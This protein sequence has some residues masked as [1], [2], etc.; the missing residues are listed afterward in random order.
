M[1]KNLS[2]F[3]F[4][5]CFTVSSFRSQNIHA[6]ETPLLSTIY[7]EDGSYIIIDTTEYSPIFSLINSRSSYSKTVSRTFT[8]YGSDD[9]A[10]WDV[11]L[12]ATF[13][14]DN[15]TS[16]CTA[17]SAVYHIY[18]NSWSCTSLTSG[19]A[20]NAAWADFTFVQK[21]L[22]ITYNTYTGSVSISC[23]ANGTIS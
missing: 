2:I 11:V 18:D 22:F 9:I 4:I 21:I 8:F 15:I 3:I 20:G 7:N 19:K 17:S 6:N 23:S 5:L 13:T 14:Y 1:K 10:A 12:T 16:Q